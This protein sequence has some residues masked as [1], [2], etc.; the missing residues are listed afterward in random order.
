MCNCD[1]DPPTFYESRTV[2]A[3]K[4]HR[5]CEC[6][7][8]IEKGESHEY[9]KGLWHGR[10]KNFR[11]CQTCLA[12]VKAAEVSCYCFGLLM[13]EIDPR[14]YEHLPCVA[15]FFERRRANWDALYAKKEEST[16]CT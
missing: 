2:R 12:I 16:P 13:D 15:E 10:F 6:L 9:A 3:R 8:T 5:C 4:P 7:R 14:D 11:T 1:Y